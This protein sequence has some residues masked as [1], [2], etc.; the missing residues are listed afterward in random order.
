MEMEM[1]PLDRIS[2]ST[3]NVR[4]DEPFG[5]EEDQELVESIGSFGVLQPIIVRQVGDMYELTAGRRRFLSAR[6]SG[7]TE[8]PCIVKDLDDYEALDI[9]LSEN[10]FRKDLDPV[11]L[12]R[13]LKRRID[14][15]GI[16]LREYARKI[17][18]PAST[19]SDFIRMTDLSPDMQ[20]EVKAGTVNFREALKVVRMNLPQE[21]EMELARDAREGGSDSFKKTLDRITAEQE[22]RGAPKGLQI[23]RISWG[24]ESS[25]YSALKQFAESDGIELSEYCQKILTKHV[26][27]RARRRGQG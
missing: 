12:G 26:Q 14:R 19:L 6:E 23:V 9:S 25:E 20:N 18:K 21:K 15:S 24:H 8:I 10:I 13:A 4:A 16:S 5:D 17:G 27:N 22:K 1:I 7:L 11:S 2:I 3:F